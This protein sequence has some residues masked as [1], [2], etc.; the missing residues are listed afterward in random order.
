MHLLDRRTH[1]C[2]AP[3]CDDLFPDIDPKRAIE[4]LGTEI[5]G[6]DLPPAR[7][8]TGERQFSD[9][10][11]QACPDAALARPLAD[12]NVIDPDDIATGPD[13]ESIV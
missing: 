5:G 4:I 3:S 12:E 1:G 9:P 10:E 2:F 6:L 7:H 8:A 13:R 11:H